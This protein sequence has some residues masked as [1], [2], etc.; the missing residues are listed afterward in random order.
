LRLLIV[1]DH[2]LFAHALR[3]ALASEWL[4]V[5]GI[6]STGPEALD[7]TL[8]LMPDVVVLDLDMPDLDGRDAMQLL[9]DGGSVATTIVLT[10]TDLPDRRRRATELGAVAF[11]SKTQSLDELVDSLR[12]AAALAGAFSEGL[13]R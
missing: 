2:P 4:E 13:Q 3:S 6:A 12:T 7:M 10:G 11:L 9:R 8:A 1:D 5:V